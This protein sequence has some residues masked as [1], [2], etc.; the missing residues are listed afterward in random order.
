MTDRISPSPAF[1]RPRLRSGA[2]LCISAVASHW[3]VEVISSPGKKASFRNLS[4]IVGPPQVIG[5]SERLDRQCRL[6]LA[7][8]F[9]PTS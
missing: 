4:L 7:F 6:V 9:V 3:R 1:A 8:A 5:C 2:E